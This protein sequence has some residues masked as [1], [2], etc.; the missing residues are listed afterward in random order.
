M[1][2]ITFLLFFLANTCFSQSIV[3]EKLQT[4]AANNPESSSAYLHLGQYYFFNSLFAEASTQ[5]E[6]AVALDVEYS[7]SYFFNALAYEGQ[8]QIQKAL[9]NY[10]K[11]IALES[12]TEYVLR[13]AYL[14]YKHKKYVGAAQDC[15][16]ILEV[17]E[18][19][20][21]IK[22]ILKECE[23]RGGTAEQ[24][25]ESN[26]IA[27]TISPETA[28]V[29][30]E[31]F[32][33][34]FS[35]FSDAGELYQG[36]SYTCTNKNDLALAVWEDFIKHHTDTQALFFYAFTLEIRNETAKA[37]AIYQVMELQVADEIQESAFENLLGYQKAKLEL[38]RL[39]N[40]KKDC[41]FISK[42]LPESATIID[43]IHTNNDHIRG[44]L[45]TNQSSYIFDVEQNEPNHYKLVVRNNNMNKVMLTHIKVVQEN[46]NY[47]I[48]IL[49]GEKK[50]ASG[51]EWF[52]RPN[53][54]FTLNYSPNNPISYTNEGTR[55]QNAKNQQ[56][57]WEQLANIKPLRNTPK[58]IIG[59]AVRVFLVG[60]L[61]K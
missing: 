4:I 33:R 36:M 37:S 34:Q 25:L 32:L 21:D 46:Q 11:A 10:D 51:L 41:E 19:M 60:Y 57:N 2:K 53:D 17:Y 24:T 22:R 38:L 5:F 31:K 45:L 55:L 42:H 18:T 50:D 27:T 39:Q 20:P 47:T 12:V 56:L 9:D 13:R 26:E 16:E 43:A 15:R 54:V 7:N 1:K 23:S 6:K 8:G 52:I 48:R 58:D 30:I 61:L 49:W 44:K 14:R 40:L 3:L 59:Y 35:K 29:F 28:I